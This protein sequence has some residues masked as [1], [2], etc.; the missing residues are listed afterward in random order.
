MYQT[1]KIKWDFMLPD[2]KVI[3]TS[4]SLEKLAKPMRSRFLTLHVKG[5]NY[6]GIYRNCC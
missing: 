2:T 3:A 4:N 1:A 6:E 5:Y